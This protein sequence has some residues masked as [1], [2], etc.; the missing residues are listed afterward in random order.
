M[1]ETGLPVLP[2]IDTV[3][4]LKRVRG[5]LTLYKELLERFAEGQTGTEAEIRVALEADERTTAERLA[6]TVKGLAATIGAHKLSGLAAALEAALHRDESPSADQLAAFGSEL[7][8]IVNT[9]KQGIGA[10]SIPD[11]SL[12]EEKVKADPER[13]AASLLRISQMLADGDSAVQD[14]LEQDQALLAA[15]LGDRRYQLVLKAVKDYDF[16][17]ALENLPT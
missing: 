17:L 5:K 8:L 4:G 11:G 14:L 2:G 6:H 9:I 13:L 16:D 1:D 3:A 15:G 7:A 12:D 10:Q